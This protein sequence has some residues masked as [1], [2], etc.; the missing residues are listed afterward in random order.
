MKKQ[1]GKQRASLLTKR[2]R[3]RL[4]AQSTAN[5]RGKPF[6]VT[7]CEKHGVKG[8]KP[9]EQAKWVKVGVPNNKRKATFGLSHVS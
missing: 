1:E 2:Q 6:Y 5:R 4:K 3:K 8:L 7:T 9:N